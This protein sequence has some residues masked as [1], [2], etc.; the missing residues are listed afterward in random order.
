MII[1][2]KQVDISIKIKNVS[3]NVDRYYFRK[4]CLLINAY[5]TSI[6]QSINLDE[7]PF[8]VS[9]YITS[10]FIENIRNQ[11]NSSC[12]AIIVYQAA[13]FFGILFDGIIFFKCYSTILY[14][15]LF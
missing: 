6:L 1:K 4:I 7:N 9:R 15:F 14:T 10:Y 13:N 2:Y 5:D 11:L 8:I 3:K 12:K